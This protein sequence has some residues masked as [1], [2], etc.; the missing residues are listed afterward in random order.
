MLAQQEQKV[1]TESII[2]AVLSEP[3]PIEPAVADDGSFLERMIALE[4]QQQEE[5]EAAA[6]VERLALQKLQNEAAE[7]ER[8]RAAAVVEANRA[9]ERTNELS[10]RGGM[11]QKNVFDDDDDE[12]E[13]DNDNDNDDG[14]HQRWRGSKNDN[15]SSALLN[16]N[17]SSSFLTS[18]DEDTINK[19]IQF[20]IQNPH[21]EAALMTRARSNPALA[22][23]LDPTSAG[24]K[25]FTSQLMTSKARVLTSTNGGAEEQLKQ[26]QQAQTANLERKKENQGGVERKSKKRS[27]WDKSDDNATP[28]DKKLLA[29]KAK[30][31]ELNNSMQLEMN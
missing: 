10:G 24:G 2:S 8:L 3:D 25:R 30:A 14:R 31:K 4:K 1:A 11:E 17:S 12:D 20:I 23:I 19:T 5:K 28:A 16:S 15:K 7:K 18:E 27:R 6:K 29:A 9:L 26:A 22:F 21:Q 13:D